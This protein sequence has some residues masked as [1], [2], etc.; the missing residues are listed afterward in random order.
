VRRSA[1]RQAKP[2]AD[3]LVVVDDQAGDLGGGYGREI[4]ERPSAV[5]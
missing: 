2:L 1:E 4:I 5:T 3:D